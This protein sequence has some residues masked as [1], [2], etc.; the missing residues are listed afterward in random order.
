MYYC[1][2][3]KVKLRFGIVV[4]DPWQKQGVG[5]KLCDFALD[6]ARKRKLQTV[7]A[8]VMP[9]NHVMIHMFE[10]RGFVIIDSGG[11]LLHAQL[12]LQ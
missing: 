9:N 8:D 7:V 10:K 3:N 4:A 11:A 1:I 6:I 2:I 5:N 12:E